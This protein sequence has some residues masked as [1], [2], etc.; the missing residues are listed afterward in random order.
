MNH[1][2]IKTIALREYK[3]NFQSPIAYI[4]IVAYLL[5]TGW[6]FFGTFFLN[7]V[8]ELRYFTN[9]MPII[10]SIV[11]P[12]ITM[13]SFSEEFNS[14]SFEILGT[15]PLKLEEVLIRQVYRLGDVCQVFIIAYA[16]LCVNH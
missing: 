14:G 11:I 15:L 1:K 12:A 10:F 13:K 8:A 2:N 6:F 16:F 3:S 5:F 7:N 4:V 9:L